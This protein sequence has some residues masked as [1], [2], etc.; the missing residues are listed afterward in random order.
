M[1]SMYWQD[2]DESTQTE[3]LS[4]LLGQTR[5][6]HGIL[7]RRRGS[8]F[9]EAFCGLRWTVTMKLEEYGEIPPI[10]ARM[11]DKWAVLLCCDRQ[12]SRSPSSVLLN[13]LLT[14]ILKQL[15]LIQTGV[16]TS[17]ENERVE[18][19][20]AELLARLQDETTVEALVGALHKDLRGR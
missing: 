20:I 4:S 6:Y 17:G 5:R 11:G 9:A 1:W 15:P 7:W 16:S 2:F 18:N 12:E 13:D 8:K 19:N 14:A 10:V 3:I